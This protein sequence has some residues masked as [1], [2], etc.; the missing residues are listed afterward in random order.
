MILQN[1]HKQDLSC[2]WNTENIPYSLI[3][4]E[5]HQRFLASLYHNG[6]TSFRFFVSLFRPVRSADIL[7]P[8]T[9]ICR[10][11]SAVP[12]SYQRWLQ[13]NSYQYQNN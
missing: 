1:I 9:P 13:N 6:Y 7:Q 2:P 11:F 10:Y 5:L 12:Q 4:E 8:Q 3:E